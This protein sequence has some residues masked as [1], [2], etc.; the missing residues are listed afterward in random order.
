MQLIHAS[1]SPI[2]SPI[3]RLT[4]RRTRKVLPVYL[5]L[6][7]IPRFLHLAMGLGRASYYPANYFNGVQDVAAP[8]GH[9][10]YSSLTLCFGIQMH[11]RSWRP[12]CM[13]VRETPDNGAVLTAML[14][15]GGTSTDEKRCL[16]G[17]A[18]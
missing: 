3:A 15:S 12:R 4:V 16:D 2:V 7:A 9:E 11:L 6:Q 10:S 17:R 13:Q 8:Q 1:V 5:G 18:D 14:G